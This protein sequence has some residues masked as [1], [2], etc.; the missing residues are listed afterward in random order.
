MTIPT[1][2]PVNMR[3]LLIQV[4]TLLSS[5][6]LP[7]EWRE[8]R[9]SRRQAMIASLEAITN[10]MQSPAE[11]LEHGLHPWSTYVILPIFALANAGLVLSSDAFGRLGDPVS[12]GI[13]FGLVVGKPLGISLFSWAAVRAGLADLPAGV[14]WPSFFAASCLAGI[15]FTMSLFIS[16]AAFSD[17]ALLDVAKLAI[18]VASILAAVL[19]WSLLSVFSKRAE[20][21]TRRAARRRAATTAVSP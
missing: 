4:I 3:A 12:L 18:F 16:D 6:E 20:G 9:D 10:R 7:A 21:Q 5:F 14:A 8:T 13:I 11:R 1:R 17:P 2:S 19:G 15:G